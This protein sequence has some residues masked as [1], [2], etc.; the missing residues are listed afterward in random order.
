MRRSAMSKKVL[1]LDLGSNSIGWALLEEENSKLNNIIALGSR[2]FTKAVEEKTPTPKNVKRRD[3]RLARRVIQRR[4]HRKQRMLNYL[5]K[6]DLLPS[7]IQGHSQPEIIL[8][9]LGDPYLLRAKALDHRLESHELGR[10]LLHLVQRRGF[11]SNRKTLLGDMVN[12]PDVLEILTE[13]EA[14][15]DNSSEKAKEE[16]AF[17]KDISELR[18]TISEEGYRT[19]GEYLA[20]LNKHDC[21]RNRSREGGHLRTDRQMYREE[22]DLIWKKQKLSHSLLSN[23]IKEQIEKI[24]FYQR[25]LKL[26]SDRIGKCSLEPTRKRANIA[27][28]EVQRFRYLQ[29]INNLTYFDPWDETEK[30]LSSE[31]K[32]KMVDLFESQP[33]IT[34]PKIRK[35]LGFDK[36]HEFNCRS[37]DPI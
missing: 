32:E 4:S 25:P 26:R 17:K 30:N 35:T 8:N 28:L 20:S 10:V 11:L 37:L 18:N 27:R 3:A 5:V 31:Q 19:L 15:D 1:G 13:L 33:T 36:K 2:I 23:A 22:L 34:F 16:T 29:D 12:D 7:E 6:L 9:D 24:I 21:K 14:D